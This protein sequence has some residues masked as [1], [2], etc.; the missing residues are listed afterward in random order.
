MLGRVCVHDGY[1]TIFLCLNIQFIGR[2]SRVTLTHIPVRFWVTLIIGDTYV[3]IATA[4]RVQLYSILGIFRNLMKRIFSNAMLLRLVFVLR[5]I[6]L[7][8]LLQINLVKVMQIA[9][10]FL[11]LSAPVLRLEKLVIFRYFLRNRSLW[12]G[13]GNVVVE[14][15]NWFWIYWLFSPWHYLGL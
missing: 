11:E 12:K 14:T 15:V 2:Q 7:L 8:Q 9:I 10:L 4:A 3:R 1:F 6:F 13:I 5:S